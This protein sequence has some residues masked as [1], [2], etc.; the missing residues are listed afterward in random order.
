MVKGI[1]GGLTYTLA[2]AMDDASNTGGGG[3]AV[4]QN[5]QDLAAEY[6]RSSF[7]RRHQVNANLSFELPFGPN[8]HWLHGGG[9]RAAV[10]GGWRGAATYTFQTGTPLTPIVVGGFADVARGSSGSLRADAV[11]GQPLF[12]SGLP[13][14]LFVNPAAFTVPQPGQY[15]N[16]GRNSVT[17]PNNSVLNA[18]F[19][20]DIRMKAN[21][22]VTLQANLSNIF[23]QENFAGINMNVNTNQFGQVTRFS[24]ARSAQLSLRFR[25]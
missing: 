2:K 14:P 3:T 4:A 6:S 21:R 20:R 18:Q 10:F 23:N 12:A 19:S 8:K 17:G 7:D 22:A 9:A 1:G 5:D 15:G 25:F 16:A 24:A 11:T 13:F